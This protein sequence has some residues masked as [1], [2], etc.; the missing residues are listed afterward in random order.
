MYYTTIFG[1]SKYFYDIPLKAD[2]KTILQK[3]ATLKK[4]KCACVVPK[5]WNLTQREH[6]QLT[7]AFDKLVPGSEPGIR[8][9][10]DFNKYIPGAICMAHSLK[11]SGTKYPIYCL[12]TN[13]VGKKGRD[14]LRLAFDVV[15]EVPSLKFKTRLLQTK[16]QEEIYGS[17]IEE[18]FTKYNGLTLTEYKKVIHLDADVI[19]T[20]N[21]DHLFDLKAPAAAFVNVWVEKNGGKYKNYKHNGQIVPSLMKR[22]LQDGFTCSGHLL[23]LEPN[24]KEYDELVDYLQENQP[25]NLGNCISGFDEQVLSYFYSIVKNKTWTHLDHTYNYILWHAKTLQRL[26]HMP[27]DQMLAPKIIHFF[28]V[29]KPWQMPRNLYDDVPIWWQMMSDFISSSSSSCAALT[30]LVSSLGQDKLGKIEKTCPYCKSIEGLV[31][32]QLDQHPFVKEGK[33]TCWRV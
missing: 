6:E 22:I 18:S 3:L 2:V 14:M 5:S 4:Q 33:I 20:K 27:P 23:V 13:D 24:R 17:W 8:M 28:N 19:V 1:Q 15:L 16:K 10:F 30:T 9:L 26:L 25:I 12:V 11:V 29:E 31:S 32:L 7:Q 21:L